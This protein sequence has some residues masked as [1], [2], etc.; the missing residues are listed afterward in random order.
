VPRKSCGLFKLRL[1]FYISMNFLRI[2]TVKKSIFASSKCERISFDARC[3]KDE[4]DGRSW[5]TFA[6]LCP[7]NTKTN[8]T[9]SLLVRVLLCFVCSSVKTERGQIISFNPTTYYSFYQ[10]RSSIDKK[11]RNISYIK[12]QISRV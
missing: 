2:Y 11:N 1:I 9:F 4:E 5:W 7:L 3:G 8:C 6:V 12:V 10:R